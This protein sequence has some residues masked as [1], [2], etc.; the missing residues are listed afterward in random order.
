[1]G[2]K[3]PM[4]QTFIIHGMLTSSIQNPYSYAHKISVCLNFEGLPSQ[5][6]PLSLFTN[7]LEIELTLIRRSPLTSLFQ[8]GDNSS[9]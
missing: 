7:S 4:G 1:M 5:I 6:L 8:R 3:E 2:Q 9:L